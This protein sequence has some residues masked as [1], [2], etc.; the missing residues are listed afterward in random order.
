MEWPRNITK[1]IKTDAKHSGFFVFCLAKYTQ[2]SIRVFARLIRVLGITRMKCSRCKK[3]Y[4]EKELRY[5]SKVMAWPLG[6]LFA[7]NPQL[8]SAI[9]EGRKKY[10]K[11]CARVLNMCLFFGVF[12][13]FIFPALVY[14]TT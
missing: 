6:I 1:L 11:E 10:C 5:L 12:F 14:L 7:I 9:R 4:R 8:W 2:R 13:F 3:D